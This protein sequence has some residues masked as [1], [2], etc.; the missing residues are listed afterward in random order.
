MQRNI[1]EEKQQQTNK[2]FID[3]NHSKDNSM[4]VKFQTKEMERTK[5]CCLYIYRFKSQKVMK[6]NFKQKGW[7]KRKQSVPFKTPGSLKL[8]KGEQNGRA[9]GNKLPAATIKR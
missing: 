8:E 5:H 4:G 7:K 2:R 6:Y 3:L 1:N 9:V